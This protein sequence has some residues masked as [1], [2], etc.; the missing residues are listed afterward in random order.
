M[1]ELK[2]DDWRDMSS[3]PKDATWVEVKSRN[4]MTWAAHWAQDLSGEEQPVFSGFFVFDG[5]TGYRELSH[6]E[7]WRPLNPD[8]AFRASGNVVC[9]RCH[10]DYY[11]HPPYKGEWENVP[12]GDGKHY[13]LTLICDGSIVK[14]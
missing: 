7:G 5:P 12:Y 13:Y 6:I 1:N 14:L 11:S 3:A 2:L 10:Y 4:G 8:N 9:E